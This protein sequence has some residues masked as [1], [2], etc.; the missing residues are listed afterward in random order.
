MKAYF[1][2]EV[3]FWG[4]LSCFFFL[5]H[6][7]TAPGISYDHENVPALNVPG[8]IKV[9]GNICFKQLLIL[10]SHFAHGSLKLVAAMHP[11]LAASSFSRWSSVKKYGQAPVSSNQQRFAEVSRDVVGCSMSQVGFQKLKSPELLVPFVCMTHDCASTGNYG[12][13]NSFKDR[14]QM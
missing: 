6:L 7:C 13:R 1:T 8:P 5:S 10:G 3:Q 14:K 11:L 9:T 12:F 4:L 2:S